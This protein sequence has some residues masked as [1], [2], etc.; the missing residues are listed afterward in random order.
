[1]GRLFDAVSSLVGLCQHARYEA[2]A[3]IEL[4]A[5]ARLHHPTGPDA[6]REPD[7]D[8]APDA[9]HPT[10]SPGYAFGLTAPQPDQPMRLDP[11]PLFEAILADL[12]AAAPT[13]LIA[14]RFHAAVAAAVRQVAALARQRHGVSTVALSG[15]VFANTLLAHA[16]AHGLRTDGFT[17]LR[18]RLVPPNDGGLALGQLVVAARARAAG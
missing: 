3:A 16:C 11:A 9:P 12:R 4:E 10:D 17:V 18:H 7:A 2:Q 13:A 8:R 15:G 6:D 5:A 14:A 1:M